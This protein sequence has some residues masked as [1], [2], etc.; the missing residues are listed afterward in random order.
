MRIIRSVNKFRKSCTEIV[1]HADDVTVDRLMETKPRGGA[2]SS[3]DAKPRKPP[4]LA[5]QSKPSRSAQRVR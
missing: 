1:I 2:I 5:R 3:V 4:E